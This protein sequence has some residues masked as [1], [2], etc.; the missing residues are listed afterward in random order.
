MEASPRREPIS[1]MSDLKEGFYRRSDALW[2]NDLNGLNFNSQS[3]REWICQEG[4][5]KCGLLMHAS[6]PTTYTSLVFCMFFLFLYSFSSFFLPLLPFVSFF[7][8]L[9]LPTP[10]YTICHC[11][12]YHFY[13]S[14]TFGSLWVSFQDCLLACQLLSHYH[15]SECVGYTTL[16]S[17]TKLLILFLTFLCFS[18]PSSG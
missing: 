1:N 13:P 14:I 8:F 3:L 2:K 18:L 9:L 17:Q 12:I 5:K 11:G 4:E 10:F 6:I 15:C 16:L 7:F